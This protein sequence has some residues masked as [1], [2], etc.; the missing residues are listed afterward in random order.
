MNQLLPRCKASRIDPFNPSSM[1]SH[2]LG[3]ENRYATP[4]TG[5][6]F[7]QLTSNDLPL[8]IDI[9]TERQ[10]GGV[11]T[12][13]LHGRPI[14]PQ[15]Y[16]HPRPRHI[17]QGRDQPQTSTTALSTMQAYPPRSPHTT[18]GNIINDVLPYCTAGPPLG[19]EHVI[20]LTDVVGNIKEL[21]LLALSA[22]SGD[23]RCMDGLKNAVGAQN[24]MGIVEFFSNEWELDG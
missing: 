18:P 19:N 15:T 3:S 17:R 4:S 23:V 24:A 11:A 10:V 5:A 20:S 6:E 2:Q 9:S 21:V 22:D 16:P 12:G 14:V 7:I 13:M 1:V 8:Q